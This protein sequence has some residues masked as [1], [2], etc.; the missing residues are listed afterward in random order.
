MQVVLRTLS[1]RLKGVRNFFEVGNRI[2]KRERERKKM[3][4][5]HEGIIRRSFLLRGLI[6]D[7]T[8][9]RSRKG[10]S[11]GKL[12]RVTFI[13][14]RKK[15][16]SRSV[17]F[18]NFRVETSFYYGSW[19]KVSDRVG[20]NYQLTIYTQRCYCLRVRMLFKLVNRAKMHFYERNVRAPRAFTRIRAIISR[21]D[22]LST[23]RRE[24]LSDR[25]LCISSTHLFGTNFIGIDKVSKL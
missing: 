6:S 24:N 22:E 25:I 5:L 10:R 4:H 21:S 17:R 11:V 7:T 12:F 16:S 18:E 13:N 20:Q 1:Y 3:F 9:N 19:I 8:A 14:N 23:P 15:I 2:E